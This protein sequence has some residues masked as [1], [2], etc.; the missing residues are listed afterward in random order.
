MTKDLLASSYYQLLL[1]PLV[2]GQWPSRS[3]RTRVKWP[4]HTASQ[5]SYCFHCLRRPGGRDTH[6][7]D[8][9]SL[10]VPQEMRK[11]GAKPRDTVVL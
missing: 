11:M 6:S 1:P 9:T 5:L 4:S 7:Q 8:W 2:L 3:R 10:Q